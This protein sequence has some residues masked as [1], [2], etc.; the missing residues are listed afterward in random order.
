MTEIII[1]ENDSVEWALRK[2]RRQ[3]QRSGVL[4]DLKKKRY[5]VKPSTA[6]RRKAEAA[7]RRRRRDKAGRRKSAKRG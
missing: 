2:F 6:R 7:Q 4:K 5:Y 1:G 3:V